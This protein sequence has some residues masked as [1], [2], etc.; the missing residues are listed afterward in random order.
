[1]SRILHRI[2]FATGLVLLASAGAVAQDYPTRLVTVVVP[3]PLAA[4]PT[5]WRG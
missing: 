4:S 3:I 2:A 1:M 5:F